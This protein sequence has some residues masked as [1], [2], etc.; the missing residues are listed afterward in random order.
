[1]NIVGSTHSER[2]T[3]WLIW[4]TTLGRS[5][6]GVPA[7]LAEDED[8]DFGR[9]SWYDRKVDKKSKTRGRRRSGKQVEPSRSGD[10]NLV[11]GD[12]G[13]IT[14]FTLLGHGFPSEGEDEESFLDNEHSRPRPRLHMVRR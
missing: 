9:E 10:Q 11:D 1:M 3:R 13:R 14:N 6:N 2:W 4:W 7:P 5:L 8:S 12:D